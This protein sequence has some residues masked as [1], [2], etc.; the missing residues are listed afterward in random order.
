MKL[1]KIYK[2]YFQLTVCLSRSRKVHIYPVENNACM[3]ICKRQNFLRLMVM[4]FT[5]LSVASVTAQQYPPN[6]PH[7]PGISLTG[8]GSPPSEAPPPPG[9]RE[10]SSAWNMEQVGHN[11]LQG[12]S[13]YQPLIINQNG[14]QIAYVGHHGS[15]APILNP[16]TGQKE[17]N[18]TSI[19]DVTDPANNKY[20]AHIPTGAGRGEGGS[21]MVQVCSGTILPEGLDG[22]WYLLRSYGR[23]AHEIWNLTNPDKPER[24]TTVID[25]LSG[26]HKN[27]WECDTGIAYL[28]GRRP[29]DGWTSGNHLMIYDLSNPTRPKYIR[30]Y[31]M[32]GQQPGATSYIGHVE[33]GEGMH[34]AISAGTLKN[35]VYMAHGIGHNGVV[36][37]ADRHKL[38]TELPT[39]KNQQMK[40]FVP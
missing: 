13:A 29:D 35:R 26:T 4:L 16:L 39:L 36:I 6:R 9:P 25:G 19:V 1:T 18:G 30:D 27:W 7:I 40:K 32:P 10:V 22:E 31:G 37:I 14:R 20:L 34:G 5:A 3:T 21:Q 8:G 12:R 15:Q 33:G 23:K 2:L 17:K 38:L 28:A 11:D 24:L